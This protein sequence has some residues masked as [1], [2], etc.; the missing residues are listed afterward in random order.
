M[1]KYR[2]EP[3][4]V[5]GDV[6][7]GMPHTGRGGW[8]WYTGSASWMYRAALE[9]MLGFYLRGARQDQ[10]YRLRIEPCIPRWWREY[11]INY[12]H[13]QAV[14]RITVENPHGVCQGVAAI[15]MDGGLQEAAEITLTD[16]GKTHQVRVILGEKIS[17][18]EKQEEEIIQ[19][20]PSSRR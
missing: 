15:E 4:V 10:S 17:A 13:G 3:Y 14:Y 8:S 7:A 1:H 9:S 16:D 5:A 6:Y 20:Q 11:E 19:R 2:I 18:P 12:Q